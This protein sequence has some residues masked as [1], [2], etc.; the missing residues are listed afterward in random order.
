MSSGAGLEGP[1]TACFASS[2]HTYGREP[3]WHSISALCGRGATTGTSATTLRI[4]VLE[5]EHPWTKRH[6]CADGGQRIRALTSSGATSPSKSSRDAPRLDVRRRSQA[7]GT[8]TTGGRREGTH[9]DGEGATRTMRPHAAAEAREDGSSDAPAVDEIEIAQMLNV[10]EIQ[11][12]F[13]AAAAVCGKPGRRYASKLASDTPRR[14]SWISPS[15]CVAC[16]LTTSPGSTSAEGSIEVAGQS[17][18][19]PVWPRP[20]IT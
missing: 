10:L 14:R 12:A 17:W 13:A 9:V 8:A 20:S 18:R 1:Q 2:W 16:N 7:S 3:G 4:G 19:W 11:S 15:R 6:A 5:K